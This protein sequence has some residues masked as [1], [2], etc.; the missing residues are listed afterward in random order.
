MRL[1][2]CL[3]SMIVTLGIASLAC[4]E[5]GPPAKAPEAAAPAATPDPKPVQVAQANPGSTPMA[6]HEG[7]GGAFACIGGDPKA[8]ETQYQTFCSSCHGPGGDGDGPAAAALDPKPAKHSNG[9]YMNALTNEHLT[10][11][12]AEG[13]AAVGKSPLMAPWGGVLSEQQLKD[14]VAFVRS[15]AVPAYA[16]P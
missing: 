14:V 8:G 15:L 7:D 11:V 1:V 3:L 4:G 6:H 10:K 5:A 13:G 9:E 12:I 2:T 16:C